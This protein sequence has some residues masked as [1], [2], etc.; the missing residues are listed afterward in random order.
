MHAARLLFI[1][2]PLLLLNTAFSSVPQ[3]TGKVDELVVWVLETGKQTVLRKDIAAIM[4][5]A[6]DDIVVSER[7][8]RIEGERTI[9]IIG[10]RQGTGP[11]GIAFFF[12]ARVTGDGQAG[13]IWKSSAA[14]ELQISMLLDP[15]AGVKLL[16]N[17]EEIGEFLAEKEFFRR[18]MRGINPE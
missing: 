7:G 10:A 4:G 1:A 11:G 17:K 6:S 8:F 3:P 2:L 13:V 12:L 9:H 15:E 18:K 16:S 14:G 5:F